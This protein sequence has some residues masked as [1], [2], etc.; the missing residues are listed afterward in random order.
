MDRTGPEKKPFRLL[1]NWVDSVNSPFLCVI[2]HRPPIYRTRIG[3]N[4]IH[5]W[6]TSAAVIVVVVQN[7]FSKVSIC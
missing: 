7:P 2:S 5:P 6:D 1:Q 4:T 3:F